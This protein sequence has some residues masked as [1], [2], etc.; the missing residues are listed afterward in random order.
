MARWRG[1]RQA[2]RLPAVRARI[3]RGDRFAYLGTN[4]PDTLALLFA[5]ARLG[6][7]LVPL[8]WRL[9]PPELAHAVTDSGARL[10]IHQPAFAAAVAAMAQDGALPSAISADPATAV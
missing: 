10:L 6:A 4:A 3:G 2:G 7:I 8:N 1:G 5:A 9:A